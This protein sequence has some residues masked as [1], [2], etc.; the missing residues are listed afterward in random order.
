[1]KPHTVSRRVVLFGRF[2]YRFK[3]KEYP[4]ALSLLDKCVDTKYIFC[5]QL[6]GNTWNYTT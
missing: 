1:M 2:G 3:K 6:K 4:L 5:K